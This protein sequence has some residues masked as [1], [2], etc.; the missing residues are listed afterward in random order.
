[1]CLAFFIYA[2][3][4]L[5]NA[6]DTSTT[7]A[8]RTEHIN[9]IYRCQLPEG[10]FRAFPGS[11]F[12]RL[13]NEQNRKWDPPNLPATFFALQTLAILKDDFHR[14]DRRGILELLPKLQ[15]EDGSFGQMVVNGIIEGGH[16]SRFGYM[17]A[18]VRW[19]LRGTVDG[20]LD[21][22]PDINVDQFCRC[23]GQ[24]QVT[25]LHHCMKSSI[26]LTGNVDL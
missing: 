1:M 13:R 25:D 15:R 7:L 8:E 17:A 10:G 2:A 5:L 14:L 24:A 18:G 16:D 22:I 12:G 19:M 9:W 26:I 23:I 21:G 3:I 20:P 11:D 6:L 4:D